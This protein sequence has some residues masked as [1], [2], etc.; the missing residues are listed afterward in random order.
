[1]NLIPLSCTKCGTSLSFAGSLICN[2]SAC[3]TPHALVGSDDLLHSVSFLP[4]VQRTDG[5]MDVSLKLKLVKKITEET[6]FVAHNGDYGVERT[7][8][9]NENK[10][11]VNRHYVNGEIDSSFTVAKTWIEEEE[12]ESDDWQPLFGNRKMEMKYTPVGEDMCEI[13]VVPIEFLEGGIKLL[14]GYRVEIGVLEPKFEEE[15][16]ELSAKVQEWFGIVPEVNLL[17]G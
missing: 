15:V 3:G 7:L 6:T 5:K 12:V 14:A 1:M 13:T 17:N 11:V 10:K 16:N 4:Y 2:C 8:K 9:V